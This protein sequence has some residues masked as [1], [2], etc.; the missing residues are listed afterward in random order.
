MLVL[1]IISIIG[2]LFGIYILYKFISLKGYLTEAEAGLKT[3]Q[4][5]I[6]SLNESI[7]HLTGKLD[8]HATTRMVFLHHSVGKGLLNNGGLRDHLLDM[9]ILV[10]S[11][12]YGDELGD[13]TD[14]NH[15]AGKF[16]ENMDKILKFKSHPD[17]YMENDMANDIV[18]FKSCFPNS[19]IIGDGESPGDPFSPEKNLANYKATFARLKDDMAKY[20]NK[21]FV[22]LTAPPRVPDI[23]T[24]DKAN[25]ARQFNDWLISDFQPAYVND[26]GLDNFVVF[27]LFGVLTGEDNFLKVEYRYDRKGDSHPNTIGSK[28]AVEEFIKFFRPIWIKWQNKEKSS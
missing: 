6:T 5:T 8:D 1:L 2:N 28:K 9:G 3:T 26:T 19:D 7:A 22:Y 25:R 11:A 13:D 24:Q 14:M 4:R 15:W 27:D 16:R 12:T 23:T 10:K 17:Q 20:P 21:L 18:M